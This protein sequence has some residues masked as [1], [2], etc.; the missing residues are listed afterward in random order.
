MLFL[1]EDFLTRCLH[2]LLLSFFASCYPVPHLTF[3]SVSAGIVIV[4]GYRLA[5]LLTN[6][7]SFDIYINISGRKVYLNMSKPLKILT[8][9]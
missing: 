4:F 8:F 3:G 2:Q 6:N 5:D 1:F 9:A 7:Q